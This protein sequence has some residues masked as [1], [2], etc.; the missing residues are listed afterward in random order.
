MSP[1]CL[2]CVKADHFIF[3]EKNAKIG[4][5]FFEKSAISSWPTGETIQSGAMVSDIKNLGNVSKRVL[6]T[7]LKSYLNSLT[8]IWCL[9]ISFKYKFVKNVQK[10]VWAFEPLRAKGLRYQNL[11]F[12]KGKELNCS[13]NLLKCDNLNLVWNSHNLKLKMKTPSFGYVW[14]RRFKADLEMWSNNNLWPA[15]ACHVYYSARKKRTDPI[16]FLQ[17]EIRSISREFGRILQFSYLYPK[18]SADYT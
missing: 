16:L 14:N 5:F 8:Y 11:Q 6:S 12:S 2:N 3:N 7:Q 10:S 18:L 4:N 15:S 9:K 17:P 13:M 1:T